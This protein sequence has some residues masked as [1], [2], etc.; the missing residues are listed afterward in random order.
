[1]AVRGVRFVRVAQVYRC[2]PDLPQARKHRRSCKFLLRPPR[3]QEASLTACLE[4]TRRLYHAAL[5]ERR[6]A[7]RTG[8]HRAGAG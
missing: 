3:R 1:M 2:P 7:W 5:E 4:G 6:A 8:R